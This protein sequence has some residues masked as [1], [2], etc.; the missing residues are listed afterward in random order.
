MRLNFIV[1]LFIIA[2]L[3]ASGFFAV[4]YFRDTTSADSLESDIEATNTKVEEMNASTQSLEAE[5]E[6]LKTSQAEVEATLTSESPVPV[7]KPDSTEV[8]RTV[9]LLGIKHHLT[10]IPLSTSDWGSAKVGQ[11]SYQVFKMNFKIEGT[12]KQLV[13]FVRELPTLYPVLVIES[14]NI[15]ASGGGTSGATPTPTPT[16]APESQY[17]S[18]LNIAVYAR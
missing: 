13:D 5:I 12:E 7:E 11:G 9:M 10:I 1:V 14:F 4:N 8:I 3:G 6:A 16:P 17:S 18:N 2:A 15:G